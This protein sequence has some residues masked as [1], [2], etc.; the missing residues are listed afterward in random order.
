[1]IGEVF[2]SRTYK[3]K[4][5]CGNIYI[6]VID[7]N[8]KPHRVMIHRNSKFRCSL[9]M[10]D[11]LARQ[12]TFQKRRDVKQL[13]ADLSHHRCESFEDLGFAGKAALKNSKYTATSCCDAVA[14]CLKLEYGL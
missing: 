6:T 10:R 7:K 4:V 1:M 9:V 11:A 12:S 14:R 3:Y 2:T 8:K 5:G 13:I